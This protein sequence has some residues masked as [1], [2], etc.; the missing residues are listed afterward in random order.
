[1]PLFL[2]CMALPSLRYACHCLAMPKL[3]GAAPSYAFAVRT[4]RGFVMPLPCGGLLYLRLNLPCPR[5]P[6][7]SMRCRCEV[8]HCFSPPLPCIV[9]QC[10]CHAS[11]RLALPLPRSAINARAWHCLP[12]PLRRYVRPGFARAPLCVPELHRCVVLPC[13]ALTLLIDALTDLAQAALR[14]ASLRLC[15]APPCSAMALLRYAAE[16][17]RYAL[18]CRRSALSAIQCGALRYLA[19]A[20]LCPTIPSP[21][22]TC[23]CRSL[24]RPAFPVPLCPSC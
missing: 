19:V 6:C 5:S 14:L 10:L 2:P 1:M 16:M 3:G 24:L 4:V 21:A 18:R 17:F 15:H 23:R 7:E 22:S 11:P 9:M 20:D 12:L 8:A 13:H